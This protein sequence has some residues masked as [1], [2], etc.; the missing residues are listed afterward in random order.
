VNA[1][2]DFYEFDEQVALSAGQACADTLRATTAAFERYFSGTRTLPD[3]LCCFRSL[4]WLT[5]VAYELQ[6]A[7]RRQ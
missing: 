5:S 2:L 6:L 4:L 1:I 7:K 3:P